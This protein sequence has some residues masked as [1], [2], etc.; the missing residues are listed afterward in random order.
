MN[1]IDELKKFNIPINWCTI[2][3]GWSGLGHI[4][5][6]LGGTEIVNYALEQLEQSPE[7]LYNYVLDLASTSDHEEDEI[8]SVLKKIV[9]IEQCDSEAEKI[10][11]CIV[12][13]EE[14]L[15]NLPNNPIDGLGA[16]TDFW[17]SLDYPKYSPHV[18]QG[19][20]NTIDPRDYYSRGNYDN[21]IKIHK[22]WIEHKVQELSCC[23]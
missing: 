2:L 5:R 13:L 14:L 12:L 15:G 17:A 1:K 4:K 6:I 20:G 22:A 16:I 19:R 11:W 10:K 18:F 3:T 21:L 7:K 23:K 8:D 9:A